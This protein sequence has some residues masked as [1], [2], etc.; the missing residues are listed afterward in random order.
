MLG[1]EPPY[2]G[3][4]PQAVLG[5]IKEMLPSAPFDRVSVGF[6]GVV[7]EGVTQTAP[8]WSSDGPT[9]T[10]WNSTPSMKPRTSRFRPA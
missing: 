5:L 6:P 10:R 4:T 3:S 1:G 7:V 9:R 2:T 8:S